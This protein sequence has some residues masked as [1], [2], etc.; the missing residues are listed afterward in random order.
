METP[1]I[2]AAF[3]QTSFAE[4]HPAREGH[5]AGEGRVSIAL[6]RSTPPAQAVPFPGAT[7]RSA[8]GELLTKAG[9]QELTE[10]SQL[11]GSTKCS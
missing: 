10:L 11:S 4:G 6:W 9:S 7:R 5:P 8:H 1:A 3:F 2:L